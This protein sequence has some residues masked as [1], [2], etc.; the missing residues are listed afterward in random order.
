VIKIR[1]DEVF[2]IGNLVKW[3]SNGRNILFIVTGFNIYKHME[4]LALEDNF[5]SAYSGEPSCPHNVTFTGGLSNSNKE[6]Y[7]I[8]K[9][10][11]SRKY[12][13]RII[14]AML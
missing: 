2:R 4:G 1:Y 10:P 6:N 7:K 13:D 9:P 3:K 5:M 8:I 14:M 11:I 12:K